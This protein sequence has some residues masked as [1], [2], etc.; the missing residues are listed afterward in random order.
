MIASALAA[1]WQVVILDRSGLDFLPFKD[2]PNAHTR[3]ITPGG[4]IEHLD[5]LFGEIQRRFVKLREVGA[6]TWGRAGNAVGGARV[7]TVIDEF[8]NLADA[9]PDS[10]RKEMW[11]YAR[12]VASEGRKAG[13]HLAIA[14]QDPSHKSLDLRIRRNTTPL[15]FRV[16]DDAASRVILNAN[17]AEELEA[18]Q[19]LTV[20]GS[21]RRGVAF[22]P[23]DVQLAIFL[24]TRSA[25]PLPAPRWLPEVG[26]A[27]VGQETSAARIARDVGVDPADVERVLALHAG[28]ASLTEIARQVF[29]SRGGQAFYQVKRIVENIAGGATTTG[30]CA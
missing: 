2:H 28:D 3:I 29:G 18:R 4:A 13:V 17:G 9:L 22:A 27:E 24:A 21:L 26:S 12:M 5:A 1:G 16:Q 19:F 15:A 8:S 30:E 23:T 6:S 20:M 14:L 10:E 25:Q 11:R 7:L